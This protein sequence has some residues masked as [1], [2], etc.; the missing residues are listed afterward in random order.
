MKHTTKNDTPRNG[1][2][3]GLYFK[4]CSCGRLHPLNHQDAERIIDELCGILLRHQVRCAIR[5]PVAVENMG[6]RLWA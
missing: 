5:M 1:S 6:A 3:Q 4:C 2:G